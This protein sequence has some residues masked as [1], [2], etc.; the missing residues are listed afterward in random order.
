VEVFTSYSKLLKISHHFSQFIPAHETKSSLFAL[1]SVIL[2]DPFK[3]S[4]NERF[5]VLDAWPYISFNAE[6]LSENSSNT[7]RVWND[8]VFYLEKCIVLT[9][10]Y[11][12]EF[13]NIAGLIKGLIERYEQQDRYRTSYKKILKYINT[14]QVIH[15]RLD[16]MH[17]TIK[18]FSINLRKEQTLAFMEVVSNIISSCGAYG[19]ENLMSLFGI[20]PI[21]KFYSN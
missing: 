4:F 7:L 3:S 14:F 19:N 21:N 2:S 9:G 18:D 17:E 12:K 11:I 15:R 6:L 1:F 13:E 8:F 16:G 20:T 5:N 10:K